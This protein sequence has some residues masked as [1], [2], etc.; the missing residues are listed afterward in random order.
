[1][2]GP[3]GQLDGKRRERETRDLIIALRPMLPWIH[4]VRLATQDEDRRGIDI[5]VTTHQGSLFV[6]VKSDP[7]AMR[8]WYG[9]HGQTIGH[10]T[11]QVVW[12]GDRVATPVDMAHELTLI[13]QR[14]L[15]GGR[16]SRKVRD[17]A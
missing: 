16:P 3:Q 13:Y 15:R 17:C 1:M 8:R 6:Q 12:K 11:M 9:K 2:S 10:K 14:L 5:V 7:R 4:S